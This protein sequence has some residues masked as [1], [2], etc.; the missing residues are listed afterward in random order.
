MYIRL[1]ANGLKPYGVSRY[2][3]IL[4]SINSCDN[5]RSRQVQV[6]TVAYMPQQD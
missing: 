3:V 2:P 4:P 5:E 1:Y 6:V